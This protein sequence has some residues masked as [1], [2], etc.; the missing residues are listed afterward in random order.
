MRSWYGEPKTLPRTAEGK[1][2]KR[3]EQ[4]NT[5]VKRECMMTEGETIRKRC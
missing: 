1:E 4:V 3:R 5:K 2:N